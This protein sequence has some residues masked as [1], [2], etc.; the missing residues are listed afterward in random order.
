[1]V[2]MRLNALRANGRLLDA[3]VRNRTT[4]HDCE[5]KPSRPR[6]ATEACENCYDAVIAGEELCPGAWINLGGWA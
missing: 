6:L 1:M 5:G 2:N 3:I 4:R